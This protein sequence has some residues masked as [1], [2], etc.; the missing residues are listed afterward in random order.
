MFVNKN[1]FRTPNNKCYECKID[2]YTRPKDKREINR[3]RECV[4]RINE[5]KRVKTNCKVCGVEV[6][7]LLS[8]NHNKL[9]Y[10]CSRSCANKGRVGIKYD[11]LRQK[12]K[13]NIS[14]LRLA[15]LKKI[16]NLKDCMIEGCS[17]NKTY[18]IH[19]L[20]PGKDGGKY[21]VGNMFAICPNHHAEIHRKICK[22]E[23]IDDCNL[24]AIYNL[25][26]C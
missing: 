22:V 7:Y 10:Y 26:G 1:N 2:M 16:F 24:K 12:D 15:Y 21:E 9:K 18:D 3:C 6:K 14:K 17:Y 4:K 20:I 8:K 11:K 19:R 13:A 5:E 23:K 25:E